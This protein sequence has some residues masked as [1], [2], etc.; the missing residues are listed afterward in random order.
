MP[1]I[2]ES[3]KIGSLPSDEAFEAGVD[4]DAQL[5][6][7]AETHVIQPASLDLHHGSTRDASGLRDVDLTQAPTD[8]ESPQC[9]A[10]ALVFHSAQPGRSPLS[11][12][13][14]V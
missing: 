1:A 12:A 9:G 2:Q 11:E 14:R 5:P 13:Y 8:P 10:N 7:V 6:D 3:V 4:G